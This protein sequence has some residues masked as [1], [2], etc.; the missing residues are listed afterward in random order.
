MGTRGLFGFRKNG[1]DKAVYHHFDSYPKGLGEHF[2]G[3]LKKHSVES[4]S[5][6]FDNIRVIQPDIP[7]TEDQIAYCKSQGWCDLSVSDRKETDWYCLLHDL[8]SLHAWDKA[9]S[10]GKQVYIDNEINFIKDSLFCEY[11][12]ILDLDTK[13]LE[14]YQGFQ[15]HP[16][17]GNR[18]GTKKE[19]GYYPCKC[20]F[21]IPLREVQEKDSQELV[22][23]AV[24]M[25]CEPE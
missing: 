7:P 16:T 8:Q 25:M 4:L 20:F 2:I 22:K 5:D 19:D 18:Y 3:L 17:A 1:E 10:N 9:I 23:Q 15:K 11:A 14:F 12:Y 6:Y 13:E 21:K 24:S